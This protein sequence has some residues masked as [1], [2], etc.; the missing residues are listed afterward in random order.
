MGVEPYLVASAMSCVVAQ[1]LARKLCTNCSEMYMA[2]REEMLEARFSPEQAAAADGVA[3]YRKRG[4]PRC[5][6]TGY[7][8]RIG[9]L[10]ADGHE[11]GHQSARLAAR[12]PRRVGAG[13]ARRGMKTLGG[14]PRRGRLRPDVAEELARVLV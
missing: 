2:T 12:E 7:K 5:N 10:P 6:Q 11:R 8:G 4:C 9:D 14:R 13:R 1:R 3:L